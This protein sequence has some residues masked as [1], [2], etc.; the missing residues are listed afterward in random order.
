MS[1]PEVLNRCMTG[2]ALAP[3]SRDQKRD[4]VLLAKRAWEKLGQPGTFEEWRHQQVRMVTERGG[5]TEC[6]NEDFLPLQAQFLRLV[7][8]TAMAER[9][10]LKYEMEP[11]RWAQHKIMV[12]CKTASDVIDRPHEYVLSIARA[13]YKVQSLDDCSEKQ[14]WGLMFDLRRNAQRRRAKAR[15]A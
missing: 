11:L 2:A 8:Q 12:E 6:R 7:G 9:K 1:N 3:M 14:L 4:L 10:V 13:R 15:A 5:L